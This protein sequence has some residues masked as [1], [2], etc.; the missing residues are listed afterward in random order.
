MFNFKMLL[1]KNVNF[2]VPGNFPDKALPQQQDSGA[3]LT[4]SW[5]TE[6]TSWPNS[7][8]WV[9]SYSLWAF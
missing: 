8:P 3:L 1:F 7:E 6:K 9:A 2:T 4:V 5:A